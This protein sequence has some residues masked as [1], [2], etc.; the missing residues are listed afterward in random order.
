MADSEILITNIDDIATPTRDMKS[1]I[2]NGPA[3]GKI[4]MSDQFYLMCPATAAAHNAMPPRGKNITSYFTN[5]TLWNRIA[6]TNGYE[7]FQDI[8]L[9]DYIDMTSS[10]T[11]PGSTS[12]GTNRIVVAGFNLHWNNQNGVRYNALTMIPATH[13]GNAVMNDSNTTVGGYKASKMFTDILGVPVSSGNSSGTINEQLYSIFGS[14]LK[15]ISELITNGIN[16]SGYNR[17]GTNSGC[18]SGLEWVSV[19]SILL[20]EIEAYGSI[21]WGSSGYDIGSA[22]LQIPLFAKNTNDLIPNGI[23]F[24]LKDIVSSTYFA[25]V[26]DRG[27]AHLRSA[28]SGAFVRPR[29]ILAA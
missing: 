15:T 17:L 5:G 11:A 25:F 8:F 29:F 19:Q 27:N 18:S 14:H 2:V 21:V 4:T 7:P 28:S 10:V 26:D 23:Y 20:S 24:W 6:G 3:M 22:K 12:T 1:M 16:A 9:G 13:F